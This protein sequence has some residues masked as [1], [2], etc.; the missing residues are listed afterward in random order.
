MHNNVIFLLNMHHQ[1]DIHAYGA[2][3]LHYKCSCH[4]TRGV[5]F[6]RGH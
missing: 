2:L 3:F 4:M 6:R 1:V 5:Q